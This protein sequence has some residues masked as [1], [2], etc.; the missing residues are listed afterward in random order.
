MPDGVWAFIAVASF[1]MV[2]LLLGM[3]DSEKD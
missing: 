1:F 2:V 3:G